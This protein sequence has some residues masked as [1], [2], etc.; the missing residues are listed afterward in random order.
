LWQ[1][2]R[3][4]LKCQRKGDTMELIKHSKIVVGV[5]EAGRGPLAGPV[6]AA[7]V[8]LN[9]DDPIAGLKDS[10]LLSPLK[11]Q[12]LFEIIKTNAIAYGVGLANVQEI[13]ELNILWASMLA[14]ERAVEQL[15]LSP[16]AQS[17]ELVIIDG[18]RCPKN[19]KYPMQAVIKADK[20]IP[21]VS[22]ASILAKVTRDKMMIEF[23]QQ[24][25]NYQFDVHKGYPTKTHKQLI[26]QYG[27]SDIHRRS[28]KWE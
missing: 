16:I 20:L 18:N 4:S 17:I 7:A 3:I 11:R 24:Y 12:Q 10:K 1:S 25:P 27:L 19:M 23:H 5:D 28:F 22:A 15:A 26:K 6:V 14:M 8:V 9:P 13:D 21:A 2:S